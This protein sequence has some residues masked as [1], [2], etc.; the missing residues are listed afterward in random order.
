MKQ[1]HHR[2]RHRTAAVT[3]WSVAWSLI[4][5]AAIL[6]IGAPASHDLP[7][8]TSEVFFWLNIVVAVINGPVSA[9][10]LTRTFHPV[11]WISAACAL[12]FAA[13]AACQAWAVAG[14]TED[15]PLVGFAAHATGWLWVGPAFASLLCLPWLLQ[16]SRPNLA[17]QRLVVAGLITAVLLTVSRAVL[18]DPQLAAPRNPWALKA[19]GAHSLAYSMAIVLLVPALVL[20]IAAVSHLIR[21]AAMAPLRIRGA[22]QMIVVALGILIVAVFT[23]QLIPRERLGA[24]FVVSIALLFVA[25]VLYPTAVLVLV[26][27]SRLWGIDVTVSRVT[28]WAVL[29]GLTIAAYGTMLW[30]GGMLLPTHLQTVQ[31]AAVAVLAVA[32]HPLRLHVQRAVDTVVYGPASDVTVLMAELGAHVGAGGGQHLIDAICTSLARGLNLERVQLIAP[33]LPPV[34]PCPAGALTL[35]LRYEHL[36]IGELLLTPRTG[37]HLDLRTCRLLTDVAPLIAAAIHLI[38]LNEELASARA[39]IVAVRDEER[40]LVRRELHDGAVPAFAGLALGIAAARRRMSHD[41][42]AAA[43]L[44]DQLEQEANQRALQ[45]RDLART[46]LPPQLDAGDVA[47]ALNHFVSRHSDMVPEVL[48]SVGELPSLESGTLMTIYHVAVEAVTNAR[49]HARS[50]RIRVDLS[51]HASGDVRLKISDD[52]CGFDVT[53]VQG[54]VG[55]VSMRERAESIGAVLCIESFTGDNSGTTVILEVS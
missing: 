22:Y 54:G 2:V 39:Q 20:G 46:V 26:L 1:P 35:P 53:T 37:E 43:M 25:Q 38:K 6:R 52:G 32:L 33:D 27:R 31:I 51:R 41:A 55:L 5:I 34:E 13:S 7:F 21:Q 8:Y 15:W 10:L 11:A 18:Q 14:Y 50:N 48:L 12:G 36:D 17:R 24:L 28:T 3:V 47:G 45:A 29:T 49:R 16:E 42:P 9:L 30:A 4:L 40:R 44:L 19:E 23:I